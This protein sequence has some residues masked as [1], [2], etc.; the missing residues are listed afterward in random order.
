MF[1]S[2]AYRL[3]T[4]RLDIAVKSYGGGGKAVF[5]KVG[6]SASKYHYNLNKGSFDSDFLIQICEV[7]NIN[8][9]DFFEELDINN[10]PIVAEPAAEYN[11]SDKNTNKSLLDQL[12]R[13]ESK[14]DKQCLDLGTRIA[15]LEETTDFIKNHV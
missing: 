4:K 10:L 7:I 12:N 15:H 14:I 1:V 3:N 2:L 5:E 8:P 13:I 9:A 6:T 11:T